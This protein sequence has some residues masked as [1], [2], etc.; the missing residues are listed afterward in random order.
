M[1]LTDAADHLRSHPHAV[2]TVVDDEGYPHVTRVVQHF[3][4]ERCRVSLTDGRVKTR[5]L[6]TRP[7]ATLHVPGDDP[8]HWVSVVADTELS[9]VAEDPDDAVAGE[10]LEVYE[11]ISGEHDD[12]DEFRR[13]MVQQD[14]L[15]LRL[16]PRR[17]YGQL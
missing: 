6:R 8:W 11:A 2:L 9:A 16:T 5:H 14:R 4:G 17:V 7:R 13:E 3:D 15:V 1:E 12:P 10:L